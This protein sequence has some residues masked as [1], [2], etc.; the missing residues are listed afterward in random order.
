MNTS[1]FLTWIHNRLADMYNENPRCEY[2][3]R[4]Y[5][6]ANHREPTGPD[7]FFVLD[8]VNLRPVADYAEAIKRARA[9]AAATPGCEVHV[10]NLV[11]T[12]K[13]EIVVSEVSERKTPC[14]K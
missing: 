3:Q 8:G 14:P 1:E 4:L 12:Y 10:V 2:M 6:I 5:A 7:V 9:S 13:S 11:K